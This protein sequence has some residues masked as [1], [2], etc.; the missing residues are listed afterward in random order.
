MLFLQILW[1]HVDPTKPQHSDQCI[2]T[3]EL[4]IWGIVLSTNSLVC[5]S[6]LSTL[7]QPTQ[8]YSKHHD[9]IRSYL[10]DRLSSQ[11]AISRMHLCGSECHLKVCGLRQ[12]AGSSDCKSL[13]RQTKPLLIAMG[14]SL[15]RDLLPLNMTHMN[16]GCRFSTLIGVQVGRCN[17]QY[18]LK[19]L[20]DMKI[21]S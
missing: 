6:W 10:L 7:T 19:L 3:H 4:P 17:C 1:E 13:M 20:T 9:G 2:C 16:N 5:H 8:R 11:V 18:Y 15:L 14:H 21:D 12:M